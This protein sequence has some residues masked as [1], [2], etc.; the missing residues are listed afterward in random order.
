MPYT[1]RIITLT[2]PPMRGPDVERA[3]QIL[4]NHG[5]WVGKIDGIWGEI[6]G[7][8]ASDAKYK[9]GYKLKNI[10]PSYGPYLE[11]YLTG[12]KRRTPAMVY[13]A[14]QRAKKKP[15]GKAM[16]DIATKYVGIKENPP[17]SNRVMFSEWYGIIGPWCA[18]FITYVAIEAGSKAFVRGSRWAYCPF[19]LAD[20]RENKGITIVTTAQANQGDIALFDWTGDGIADHVG[21]VTTPVDKNGNFQTIEGNTSTSSD[22]DGGQVQRRTRNISSVA[23]FVRVVE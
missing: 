3:Q 2:S 21:F 16:V 22:S 8:A 19:M 7:R 15:L 11:D 10:T 13:R 1:T 17:G 6:S 14:N 9:L 12:A 4:Q 23:A 5:Y 18:M 20:A